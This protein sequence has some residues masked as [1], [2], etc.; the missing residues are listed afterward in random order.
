[1]N[2]SVAVSQVLAAP[3]AAALLRM[4]GAGG[5]AGWQ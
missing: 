3:I 4:D 1:M 5:L 2:A